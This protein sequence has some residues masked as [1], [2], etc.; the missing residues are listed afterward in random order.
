M[1]CDKTQLDKCFGVLSEWSSMNHIDINKKKSRILVFDSTP[2]LSEGK[3]YNGYP[4]VGMYKYLG[5]WMNNRLCLSFQV[6]SSA[7]KLRAYYVKNKKL[8][9]TYFSPRSLIKIFNYSQKSRMVYGMS[10]DMIHANSI[11]S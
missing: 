7:D 2:P 4:I 3:Y 8:V 10:S 5:V 9:R 6:T 1:I 11:I